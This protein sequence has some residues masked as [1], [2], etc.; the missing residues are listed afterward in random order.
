MIAC[1]KVGPDSS[2][3]AGTSFCQVLFTIKHA[4]EK[5]KQNDFTQ[6]E[7]RKQRRISA[8]SSASSVPQSQRSQQRTSPLTPLTPCE[9]LSFSVRRACPGAPLSLAHQQQQGEGERHPHPE[10]QEEALVAEH[11]R[12]RHHL[13]LDHPD[14]LRLG[15]R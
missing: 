3:P 12:L 2:P 9:I 5:R 1:V 8:A 15:D 13:P 11:R 14:R 6:R 7:Q 4:S 10:E